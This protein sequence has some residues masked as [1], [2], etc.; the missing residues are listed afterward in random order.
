MLRRFLDTFGFDY[1]F[2]SRDRLLQVRP[3][4]EMLLRAPSAIRRSWT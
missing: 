3:F 1:E 4:D 2:A